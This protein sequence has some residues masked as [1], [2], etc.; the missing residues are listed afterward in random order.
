MKV[1]WDLLLRSFGFG[2]QKPATPLRRGLRRSNQLLT[3]VGLIWFGLHLFPQ[4]VFG[5]SITADG[6]TVYARSPLPAATSERISEAMALVAKSELAVPGRSER[7][8]ICNQRWLY[9]ILGP[10]SFR[11]FAFS[12]PITGNIFVADA[13]VERNVARS[14]SS[15]YNTR[16]FSSV[17]AHEITHGLIRRRLGTF[18]SVRLPSW[19]AE[20][21]CDYVAQE[22]SFPEAEGVRLL[23]SGE[24]DPS[25]SFDY[26]VG[27]QM[28]THLIDREHL[29]F[30]AVATRGREADAIRQRTIDALRQAQR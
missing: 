6:V 7:V 27:R 20:G 28:V 19:L 15:A 9:T 23:T 16:S 13:D 12:M 14:R 24:D 22:S 21:Y 26:F 11:A 18:R 2:R 4:V 5:H 17:L 10:T 3:L 1:L 30:D 29:S 25:R 8:F